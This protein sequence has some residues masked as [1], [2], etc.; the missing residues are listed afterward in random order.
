MLA[1][2]LQFYAMKD[3]L[4]VLDS[5]GDIV[6]LFFLN[7]HNRKANELVDFYQATEFTHSTDKIHINTH[8]FAH[9]I[10]NCPVEGGRE[11]EKVN[12]PCT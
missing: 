2:T 8:S 9:M 5:N 6:F 4:L 12:K 1:L 11:R 10:E 7:I 3:L